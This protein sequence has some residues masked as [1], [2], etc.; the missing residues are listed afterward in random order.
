MNVI[1]VSMRRNDF[2]ESTDA[3]VLSFLVIVVIPSETMMLMHVL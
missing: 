1:F 2:I 3:S